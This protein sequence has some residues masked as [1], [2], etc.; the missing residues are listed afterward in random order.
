VAEN[1]LVATIVGGVIATA[2][3]VVGALLTS[4]A[5][6]KAAEVQAAAASALEFEKWQKASQ[7]KVNIQATALL[8]RLIAA[9]VTRC[10]EWPAGSDDRG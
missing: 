6:K 7:A 8:T 4:Q 3:G 10:E 5:T 2:S 1:V 9:R